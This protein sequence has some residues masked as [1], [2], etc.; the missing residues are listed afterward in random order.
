MTASVSAMANVHELE[1][2]EEDWQVVKI[3]HPQI[4]HGSLVGQRSMSI[5]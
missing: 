3:K 5:E 2:S 4:P 1:I